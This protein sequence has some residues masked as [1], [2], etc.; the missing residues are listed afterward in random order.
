M[1]IALALPANK[2]NN[3]LYRIVD[4]FVLLALFGDVNKPQIDVPGAQRLLTESVAL[5][6]AALDQIA[7]IC[8][9]VV[10][11]ANRDKHPCSMTLVG[12]GVVTKRE[13]EATIPILKEVV[14]CLFGA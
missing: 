5:F 9:L 6:D 2:L 3:S 1:R 12:G 10:A 11:F 7:A 8:P 4:G 13:H 14:D